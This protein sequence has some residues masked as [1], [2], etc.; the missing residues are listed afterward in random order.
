MVFRISSSSKRSRASAPLASAPA[1][2]AA[3]PVPRAQAATGVG[4][5]AAGRSASAG[6][7]GGGRR[8]LRAWALACS[9]NQEVCHGAWRAGGGG[10]WLR[11]WLGSWRGGRGRSHRPRAARQQR[12]PLL[13]FLQA[14][15]APRSSDQPVS[16]R[17]LCR[18]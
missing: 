8:G 16:R 12:P 17:G 11:L 5:A 3:P 7:G 6:A 4:T 15:I 13:G 10:L 18:S 14:F 1:A 2:S 9:W